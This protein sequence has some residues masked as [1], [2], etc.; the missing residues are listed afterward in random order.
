M[1]LYMQSIIGI[2]RNQLRLTSL[3]DSISQD[4]PVRF[5]DAFVEHVS[6][7]LVGFKI[8]TI[9]NEENI[10]GKL[11]DINGWLSNRLRYFIW[12][13]W[14]NCSEAKITNTKKAIKKSE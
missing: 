6:L 10:I 14:N 7:Y 12:H 9:E 3:D 8:Q 1:F 13:D 5:I 11:R 4:N 2:P